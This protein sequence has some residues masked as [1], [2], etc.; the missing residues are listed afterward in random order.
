MPTWTDLT[1]DEQLA[2]IRAEDSPVVPDDGRWLMDVISRTRANLPLIRIELAEGVAAYVR[3]LVALLAQAGIALSPRRAGLLFRSVL[4]V[5]A[6]PLA[7]APTTPPP[8][9]ARPETRPV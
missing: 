2:I 5:T 8:N 7:L 1:E 6:G 3:T 4:A 9:P